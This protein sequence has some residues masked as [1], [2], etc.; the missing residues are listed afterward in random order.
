MEYQKLFPSGA[1]NLARN[2]KQKTIENLDAPNEIY[3]RE[4]SVT[5]KTGRSKKENLFPKKQ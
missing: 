2:V 4:S 1:A 5:Q 3:E